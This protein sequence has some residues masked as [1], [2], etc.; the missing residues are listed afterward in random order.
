MSL[1]DTSDCYLP[2]T[3]LH[4]LYVERFTN[5]IVPNPES[6]GAWLQDALAL[7]RIHTLLT[8]LLPFR[9]VRSPPAST[10][11]AKALFASDSFLGTKLRLFQ[12]EVCSSPPFPPFLLYCTRA[13]SHLPTPMRTLTDFPLILADLREPREPAQTFRAEGAQG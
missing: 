2:S 11:S 5:E 6:K 7:H 12:K 9:E 4:L 3:I 13:P 8:L 10:A 1:R